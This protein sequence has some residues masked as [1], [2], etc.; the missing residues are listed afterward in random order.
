MPYNLVHRTARA[1]ML[2]FISDGTQV[3]SQGDPQTAG[4][5]LPLLNKLKGS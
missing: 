5:L 1:L 4:Q 2:L 3:L